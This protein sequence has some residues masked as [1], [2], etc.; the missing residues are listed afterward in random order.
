[1][2]LSTTDPLCETPIHIPHPTLKQLYLSPIVE[3]DVND[4]YSMLQDPLI[5]KNTL[6]IPYPYT[7]ERAEWFANNCKEVREITRNEYQKRREEYE[8]G[9]KEIQEGK[10]KY[11][12]GWIDLLRFGIKDMSIVTESKKTPGKLI[13][14]ITLS[15]EDDIK[16]RGFTGELGY[17]LHKDYRSVSG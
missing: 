15:R 6:V 13:G 16:S 11:V 2:T 3:D 9:L 4:L 10:R 8:K 7:P 17:Y 12:K 1:M 5:H 14:T